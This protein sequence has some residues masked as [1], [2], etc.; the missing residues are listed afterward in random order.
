MKISI[1]TIACAAIILSSIS[2]TTHVSAQFSGG[3]RGG[4]NLA[5]LSGQEGSGLKNKPLVQ[6]YITAFGQYNISSAFAILLGAGYSGEGVKDNDVSSGDTYK[7]MFS[8]IRVPLLAQ[9]KFSF[10]GYIEAGPEVGFLLSAKAKYN[11]AASTDVKQYIKKTDFG[12]QPGLGYEFS[13]GALSGFGLNAHFMFG[14]T[15]INRNT[16]G[17]LNSDESDNSDN[18]K[19]TDRAITFGI[20]YRIL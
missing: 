4:V 13:K 8:Y 10:G 14:L 9:Y 12:I 20:T 17:I 15:N 19:N 11:N 3:L 2:M 6:P 5:T 18:T 7:A 16:S 1:K